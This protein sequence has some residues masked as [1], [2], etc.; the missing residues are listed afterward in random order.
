MSKLKTRRRS[1]NFPLDTSIQSKQG[2]DERAMYTLANLTFVFALRQLVLEPRVH[3]RPVVVLALQSPL[4]V[5]AG[6]LLRRQLTRAR[7]QALLQ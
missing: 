5:A 4:N 2:N 3:S 7:L 6:G 1:F